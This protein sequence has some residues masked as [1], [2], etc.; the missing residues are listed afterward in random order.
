MTKS[1][2]ALLGIILLIVFIT[3]CQ[4]NESTATATDSA[5]ATAA[6]S[7]SATAG[8]ATSASVSAT[9][10]ATT[11]TSATIPPPP[12]PPRD[13]FK[14]WKVK[15]V[16]TSVTVLLMG[17][18]DK[19][20]WWEA[21]VRTADYLGNPVDKNG[22]GIPD[23]KLH[24]VAY[25]IAA[26]PEP[27]RTVALKNQLT[28]GEPNGMA[29]WRLGQPALLLVPADKK[30]DGKPEPPPRGDHF[31]CYQVLDPKPFKRGLRLVDQFDQRQKKIEEI[32]ELTPAY[33][34]VP[35]QKNY[36]DRK[37]PIIDPVNHI[38][39]YKINPPESYPIMAMTWDQF[40]PQKLNVLNSELLGVPSLKGSWSAVKK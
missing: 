4:K 28:K 31:V 26:K 10:T 9:S 33:F 3:A 34:C 21:K 29:N 13:H 38:A 24:L 7:A 2:L 20:Q 6:T 18:F 23:P 19:E 14:F 12:P 17:Q 37:E 32:R 8:T 22:E 36:K 39:I 11:A 30:L 40:A 27:M 25:S 35:V 15:P 5:G 16:E 1:R